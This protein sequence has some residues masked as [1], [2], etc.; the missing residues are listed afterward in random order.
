MKYESVR[1]EGRG[2]W[3]WM[4]RTSRPD[5]DGT[6]FPAAPAA[7]VVPVSGFQQFAKKISTHVAER[8]GRL[9]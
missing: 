8:D 2:D 5:Q 4:I 7:G 3:D 9:V 6:E 1:D